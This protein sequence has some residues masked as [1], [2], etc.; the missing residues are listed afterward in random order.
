MTANIRID[1]SQLD[2]LRRKMGAAI[3]RKVMDD[4]LVYLDGK[5]SRL[6]PKAYGA[7]DMYATPRQKRAFFALVSRGIAKLVSTGYRRR[8]ETQEAWTRDVNADGTRGVIAN[9]SPGA[10]WVYGEDTQQPFHAIAGQPRVDYVAQDEE[11]AVADIIE[12]AI[13]NALRGL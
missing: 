7:F 10:P 13:A 1:T 6:E 3:T 12:L 5:L 9:N 4:A 11:Y 2:D 8:N